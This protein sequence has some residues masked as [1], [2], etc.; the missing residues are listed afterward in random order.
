MPSE[1]V[2]A[3]PPDDALRDA[4]GDTPSWACEA[5]WDL[6]GSDLTARAVDWF[7]ARPLAAVVIVIVA[8]LFDRW[9]RKLVTAVIT[10]AVAGDAAIAL[11]R[12]SGANRV[13]DARQHARAG[14]V[15]AVACA[16]VSTL[17]WT[18]A[19]LLVLGTF[20]LD[21]AP[22]LASAGIAAVAVGL[23]AQSL[24]KDC[25]AGFFILL[26]DQY[27][28]GDDIQVDP[29]IGTVEG[30]TL[31]MT[32]IR[33]FDGTLWSVPNGTIVQVGN[34]S[35]SWSKGFLDIMVRNDA[36]LDR[37]IE[38]I[39]EATRHVAEQPD[40]AAQLIDVPDV[41]GVD[42]VGTDGTAIRISI[43]TRPGDHWRLMRTLRVEIKRRLDEEGIPLPPTGPTLGQ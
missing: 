16:F 31:R 34:R 17:V 12:L 6:S 26:E 14:T 27:G 18:I 41:L 11:D 20:D 30:L 10:R 19:I 33:G 23:G 40:V 24:V 28:V 21:L 15:A 43:K 5:A 37:A 35:R 3:A 39:T 38:I 7:V 2:A 9:L 25:I 32:R 36:D 29:V 13:S 22:L 42:R 1:L 4:C 8:A